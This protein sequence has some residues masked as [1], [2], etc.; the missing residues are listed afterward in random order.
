MPKPNPN[1]LVKETILEASKL[2]SR[3]FRNNVGLGWIGHPVIHVT[4]PIKLNLK[5]GDCVVRNARALHAG[6]CEGSSDAIGFTPV[7]ITQ[8]MVGKTLP[9]FTA[10]ESKTGKGKLSKIQSDFIDMVLAFGGI[11]GVA[12]SREDLRDL[13]KPIV[14][15]VKQYFGKIKQVFSDEIIEFSLSPYDSI[16]CDHGNLISK[17]CNIP[18]CKFYRG[19]FGVSPLQ[20]ALP[21]YNSGNKS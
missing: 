19:I 13:I 12:R 15:P 6:I 2:G 20:K 4:K 11:A 18:S 5:P 21:Y 16:L 9:I 3:L 8:E 17:S 1:D 10:V 7:L 14:N